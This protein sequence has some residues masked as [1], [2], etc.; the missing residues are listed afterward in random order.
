MSMERI[1]KLSIILEVTDNGIHP[2]AIFAFCKNSSKINTHE[3]KRAR[4]LKSRN[5]T[6]YHIYIEKKTI[7]KIIKLVSHRLIGNFPK[8]KLSLLSLK[9]FKIFSFWS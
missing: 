8:L 1:T 6:P 9:H 4:K 7:H 2:D 3:K 5:L